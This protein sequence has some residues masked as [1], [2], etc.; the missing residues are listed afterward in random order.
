ME[1]L[2]KAH[3]YLLV[4]MFICYQIM[5]EHHTIYF[6]IANN[7]AVYYTALE[8]LIK[9]SSLYVLTEQPII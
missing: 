8:L 5:G 2:R 9:L 4:S 6:A 3:E 1:L 7:T